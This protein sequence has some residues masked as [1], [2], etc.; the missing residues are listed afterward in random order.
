MPT[1]V[2]F[3]LVLS[4][5]VLIHELGHFL[6]ARTL[7]IKVEEFALGLPFTRAIFKIKRGET[8][9]GVYPVLFGGF[10]RLY[11]EE[12]EKETE[13]ERSFW[14]RGKK[15]RMMVIVAGVVMNVA[16][17]VAAFIVLYAVVGVPV[18]ER[19]KVTVVKAEEGTPAEAAGIL[20]DDRIV[21]VEGR[22]I[23]DTEEFSQAVKAWA[24]LGVNLT[25]ER[26][27][28]TA[29]FEGIVEGQTERRVVNVVPRVDPPPGQG[30]VGVVITT[31]PYLRTQKCSMLNVQCS[32]GAVG[33]GV[34]STK[35]WMGRVVTGLREIG[36]SLVA[37]KAP[38]GVSGP[39]G[40]YQLTGQVAAAGGLPLLELVAIL[41]VNLAVFN[42]LP[43][44]ALDGGRLAFIWLEWA[45]RRRI[46]PDIEQKINSW[47]LAFLLSLMVLI[48]F[49]DVIRLGL[50]SKWLGR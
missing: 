36:K 50:L 19:Q 11:G 28:G 32:T 47:G 49:Q 16:L 5:L 15:Q 14:E 7:G 8:Q 38:E 3:L 40:I 18:E 43:I 23:A 26:G 37:G 2:I 35:V 1:G 21:E 27:P 44:P 41:S 9:Y 48:S 42:V 13:K 10:V 45:L 39:V 33:Q 4:A 29:L 31:Y 25:I 6:A 24:G 17:A 22:S 30:A 12:Q 20:A 34:K 46:K